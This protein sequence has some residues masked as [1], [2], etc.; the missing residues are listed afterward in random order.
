[1][2]QGL[3]RGAYF[4]SVFIGNALEADPERLERELVA[5]AA[6]LVREHPEV[7]AIVSECTNF[8]PFSSRMREA[9]GVPVFDLYTLVMQVYYATV[10][11]EHH[12][13]L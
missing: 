13:F 1:V 3:P 4:P 11:L 10:G 9:A 6:G 5:L 7:G 8:V 12:G 2:V